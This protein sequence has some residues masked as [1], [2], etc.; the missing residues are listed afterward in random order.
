MTAIC[1]ATMTTSRR[2][3]KLWRRAG[4]ARPSC[5]SLALQLLHRRSER[6]QDASVSAR[7]SPGWRHEFWEGHGTRCLARGHARPGKSLRSAYP[8]LPRSP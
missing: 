7:V 4:A 6:S 3:N 5:G 8:T 2:D 1:R